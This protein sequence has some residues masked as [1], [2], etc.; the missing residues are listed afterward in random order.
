MGTSKDTDKHEPG[1]ESARL[2]T[3]LLTSVSVS[4]FA[5]TVGIAVS[6]IT[7]TTADLG[8]TI[9]TV[10]FHTRTAYKTMRPSILIM[11]RVYS[12]PR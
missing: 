3:S 4:G 6:A 8:G 5:K 12:L 10:S 11:L 1:A 9:R 7:Y 2:F